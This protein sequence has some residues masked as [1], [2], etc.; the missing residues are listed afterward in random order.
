MTLEIKG[1]DKLYKN[2]SVV[3]KQLPFTLSVAMNSMAEEIRKAEIANL[4]KKFT[5]RSHWYEPRKKYGINIKPSKKKNLE[6]RIFTRAGWMEQHVT[7]EDKRS[8]YGKYIAIPTKNVERTTTGKIKK[9]FRP[10]NLK[11]SFVKRDNTGD[12]VIYKKIRTRL[13]KRKDYRSDTPRVFRQYP[14]IPMYT[15]KDVAEID[16]TWYF[17]KTARELFKKKMNKHFYTALDKAMRT[18]R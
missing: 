11:G 14:I 15:L 1:L 6:V 7:G 12:L 17:Y 5:L 10:S 18:A 13:R 16:R 8:M 3:S 9:S 2:L 4:K